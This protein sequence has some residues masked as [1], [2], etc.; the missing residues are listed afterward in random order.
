MSFAV[1][2]GFN[3]PVKFTYFQSGSRVEEVHPKYEVL[4]THAARRTFVCTA[5]A[6]GIP[7]NVVMKIT[8][9][10]DYSAMKPYIEIAEE[11]KKKAMLKFDEAFK[12]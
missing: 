12:M 5:L 8:G 3:E 2:K 9:H 7:A 11:E 1:T 4:T 6:L 10:S